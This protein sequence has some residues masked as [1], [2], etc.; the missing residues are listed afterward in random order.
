VDSFIE[1][2]A[3]ALQQAAGRSLPVSSESEKGIPNWCVTSLEV[4]FDVEDEKSMVGRGAFGRVVEGRWWSGDG[5]A[6]EKVVA[7]KAMYVKTDNE[8]DRKRGEEV[9]RSVSSRWLS[10]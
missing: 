8:G 6:D 1:V 5:A 4:D 3:A 7:V 2:A 9:S 10:S